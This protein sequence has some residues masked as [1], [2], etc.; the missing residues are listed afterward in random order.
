MSSQRPTATGVRDRSIGVAVRDRLIDALDGAD[1]LVH[2]GFPREPTVSYL[3][4]AA[5]RRP[6]GRAVHAVA[7]DGGDVLAFAADGDDHPAAQLADVLR[8]RGRTGTLLAPPTIPHDAALYLERAGFELSS[9]DLLDRLR[10]SKTVGERRRTER[11]AIAATAGL[12][13]AASILADAAVRSPDD[14][15]D[16]GADLVADGET[17][18]LEGFR[19]RID[20][21]IVDAGAFPAGNTVVGIGPG[22]VPADATAVPGEGTAAEGG[23]DAL[24][25]GESIVVSVAPCGPEGYHAPLSRTFVVDGDGGERR[26]AHVAATAALQSAEALLESGEDRVGVVEAEL[27]AEVAAFG[28]GDGIESRVHG[29]GLEPTELPRTGGTIP[30]GAILALVAGTTDPPVRLADLLL[31]GDGGAGRLGGGPRSLVPASAVS[32]RS[33]SERA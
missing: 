19:R 27:T 29:V 8:E 21:A 25:A 32:R 33:R 1:A 14:G 24:P 5:G 23:A 9:T 17:L 13:T 15:V 4:E 2:A 22:A 16:G 10:A 30:D 11:A 12:S 31:V 26:R 20:A 6:T 18:T 7:V 28:F 3:L